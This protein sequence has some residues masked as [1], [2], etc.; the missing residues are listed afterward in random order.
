MATSFAEMSVAGEPISEGAM[1]KKPTG[2]G[3]LLPPEFFPQFRI[4]FELLNKGH[5]LI[6]RFRS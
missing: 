6:P 4:L 2:E 3:F 1:A 5:G